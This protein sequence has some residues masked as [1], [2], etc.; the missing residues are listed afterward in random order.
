MDD[1]SNPF[2][3]MDFS[4]SQQGQPMQGDYSNPFADMNFNGSQQGQG[5]FNQGYDQGYGQ[6]GFNQGYNQDYNQGY[7]QGGMFGQSNPFGMQDAY[8]NMTM[9]MQGG[10]GQPYNQMF[11]GRQDALGYVH[12]TR[13][14]IIEGLRNFVFQNTGVTVNLMEKLEDTPPQLRH[15]CAY[16]DSKISMLYQ[17]SFS[18]PEAGLVVPFYFC[19]ACGKLFYPKDFMI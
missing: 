1:Y 7:N 16:S 10:Y 17:C 2:A 14:Q 15:A 4:S 18:I 19:K 6:G 12:Y 3:D 8:G 9:N 13:S 5:V 11:M